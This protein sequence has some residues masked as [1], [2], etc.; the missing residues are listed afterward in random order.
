MNAQVAKE[1]LLAMGRDCDIAEVGLI[2]FLQE[3]TNLKRVYIRELL[4]FALKHLQEETNKYSE[5][6]RRKKTQYKY[7]SRLD[8]LVR[9][10]QI[11]LDQIRLGQVRLD[12]I[13]LDKIRLD[14]STNF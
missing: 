5:S 4:Y 9:L 1:Q 6:T 13:R 14:R 7:D 12:Q 2:I 10:D 3:C 11:R 8:R